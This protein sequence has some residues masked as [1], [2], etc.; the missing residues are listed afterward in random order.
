MREL[1]LNLL[2]EFIGLIVGL[3]ATYLIIDRA[4]KKRERRRW[5]ASAQFIY[6]RLYVAVNDFLEAVVLIGSLTGGKARDNRV[7]FFGQ[8]SVLGDASYTSIDYSKILD[9]LKALAELSIF[10]GKYALR[11]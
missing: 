2:A 11:R 1:L 9:H 5:A 3:I 10:E 4:L 6:A 7:H 8:A